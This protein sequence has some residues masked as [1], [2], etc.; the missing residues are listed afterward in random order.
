M[1]IAVCTL[2]INDW[3]A[4]IVRY[5][6]KTIELYAKKH[7][8]D[9]YICNDVYD[10]TRDF[11]W[12]K[13]KAVQ[14]LLPLYDIVFW[15]DADG[16]VLKPE[17][18]VPDLMKLYDMG[19]NDVLCGKDWNGVLN[20]GV[21]I[22]KNTPFTNALLHQVWNNKEEFDA[23]F[24]EQASMAQIYS[25][26]RLNSQKKIKILSGDDLFCYWSAYFPGRSF[27]FH[28]ARCAQD[29]VG[30]IATLDCY[31][32]IKMEEDQPGEYEER[33]AWC[34][35]AE[36]CRSDIDGWVAKKPVTRFSTRARQYTQELA[37]QK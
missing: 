4:R 21:M 26:N 16:H 24:H 17:L 11:P 29:R 19:E 12:Y 13:I 14:K 10:G 28:C 37:E 33:I 1:K 2:C 34:N 25:S 18:S 6:V 32:P 8:Y 3:Y 30:F 20:T 15:L 22:I 35:N 36:L 7:G 23:S 31:C 5:G 9:F 27:F